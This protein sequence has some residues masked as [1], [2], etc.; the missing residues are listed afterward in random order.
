MSMTTEQIAIV[1]STFRSVQAMGATAAELF[2]R[3]LFSV[4]PSVTE[5]FEADLERQGREFLQ[6][7]AVAV[8]GLGNT[9]VLVPII[10]QLGV[11]HVNYGVRAEHYDRARDAL[12]WMLEM[13]LQDAFTPQV[14]SAWATAYAMLAGIMKEAAWGEP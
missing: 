9:S 4:E 5:L 7:M 12:L 11:R 10:Q 14:R 8:G 1:Q 13:I 2:Y 6:V 3:R